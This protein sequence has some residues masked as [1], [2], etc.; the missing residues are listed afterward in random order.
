MSRRKI[1]W[2]HSNESVL[3]FLVY[4]LLTLS[5]ED[6]YNMLIVGSQCTFDS[7]TIFRLTNYF[8]YH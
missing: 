3:Y 2:L 6:S 8:L 4:G 1:E 5:F 7:L